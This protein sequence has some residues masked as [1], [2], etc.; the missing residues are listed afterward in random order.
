MLQEWVEEYEV[1]DDE[2]SLK[3]HRKIF[4]KFKGRKKEYTSVLGYDVQ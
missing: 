3:K 2:Y 4:D 1:R